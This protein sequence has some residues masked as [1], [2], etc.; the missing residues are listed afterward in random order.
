[1]CYDADAMEA[2]DEEHIPA[3]HMVVGP[4][5]IFAELVPQAKH[6]CVG[7]QLWVDGAA[8]FQKPEL[9]S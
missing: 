5:E 6:E 4:D 3:C 7:H 9:Q 2:L 8:G 1:M